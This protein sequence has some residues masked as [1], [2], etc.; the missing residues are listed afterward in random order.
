MRLF[1]TVHRI[2]EPLH[3][4]TSRENLATT[5]AI[6]GDSGWIQRSPPSEDA[7]TESL[8]SDVLSAVTRAKPWTFDPERAELV[9][10]PFID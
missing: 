9:A 4:W 8:W 2:P 1:A 3:P 10:A 7:S 5:F 6:L